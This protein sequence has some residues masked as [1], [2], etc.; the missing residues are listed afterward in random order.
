MSVQAGDLVEW[1]FRIFGEE[2]ATKRGRARIVE[3]G[4][5]VI[6]NEQRNHGD[7]GGFHTMC[8]SQLT[9]VERG[10]L[11]VITNNRENERVAA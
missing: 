9:V 4:I 2:F 1:S 3:D 6:Q 11:S 10:H 8:Q 5:V 7:K